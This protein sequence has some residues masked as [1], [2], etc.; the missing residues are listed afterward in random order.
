MLGLLSVAASLPVTMG[1][2]Q[3]AAIAAPRRPATE[4]VL[5]PGFG[6]GQ[7]RAVHG[8][9]T[10][11]FFGAG[12]G[13]MFMPGIDDMFIPAVPAEAAFVTLGAAGATS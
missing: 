6:I 4:S 10:G 11:R 12:G 2:I 5:S 13:V 9:A 7:V 8:A 1:V 3:A